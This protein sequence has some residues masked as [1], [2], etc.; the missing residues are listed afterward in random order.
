MANA[1]VKTLRCL[2]VAFCHCEERLA[3]WQ[4]SRDVET[5]YRADW[6]AAVRYDT[7][8]RNDKSS[9]GIR[10]KNV[11]DRQYR[12]RHRGSPPVFETLRGPQTLERARGW[13]IETE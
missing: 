7:F 13:N 8:P 10:Q 4:S 5:S 1:V 6:I 2:K 12:D 9:F 11:G 3:T